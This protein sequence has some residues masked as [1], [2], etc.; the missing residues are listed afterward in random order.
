[1]LGAGAI[2]LTLAYG[3]GRL[4]CLLAGDGTYGK[5]SSLP[6]AMTFPNGVVP[7]NVPVHPTPLYEALA[8]IV[9][10]AL[11]WTL[12]KHWSPLAIFGAYLVLSGISRFL[13]EMLRIN[14]PALFGLPQ[15]HLW[16]L[17][18]IPAAALLLPR[19]RPG[20]TPRRPMIAKTAITRFGALIRRKKCGF[21]ILPIED[22]GDQRG[23]VHVAGIKGQIQ[24]VLTGIN[25]ARPRRISE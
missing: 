25:G 14:D 8:A 12:G 15:P 4:G 20:L 3:I 5:P 18:S 7:T 6:W 9:I 17:T 16:A 19:P 13:V 22:L 2:P 21:D 11:L 10:A 23:N 1:M 24:R